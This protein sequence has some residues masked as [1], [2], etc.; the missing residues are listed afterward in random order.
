MTN[1]YTQNDYD[2]TITTM[3]P[4]NGSN[5]VSSIHAM[6]F[7]DSFY[8]FYHAYKYD[9]IYNFHPA[10]N[11]Q[12]MYSR[13]NYDTKRWENISYTLKF[14]T[15]ERSIKSI[16]IDNERIYA[17]VDNGSIYSTTDGNSWYK[18]RANFDAAQTDYEMGI[19]IQPFPKINA[20]HSEKEPDWAKLGDYYYSIDF[21]TVYVPTNTIRLMADMGETNYILSDDDIKLAN[22]YRLQVTSS[23][24]DITSGNNKQTLN[25]LSPIYTTHK[26]MGGS[27]F[28]FSFNGKLMRLVDYANTFQ[29]D[30]YPYKSLKS[31]NDFE[32]WREKALMGGTD[33]YS[34]VACNYNAMF[35]KS[36]YDV[37]NLY[38]T[39]SVNFMSDSSITHYT[40][41]FK[42]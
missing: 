16:R 7:K 13:M 19:Y 35:N 17:E 26:W 25:I 9:K 31:Y 15:N 2:K 38:V 11:G 34:I 20:S 6:S 42:Y 28:L 14:P 8:I 32:V 21:T 41:D 3:F 33:G 18:D 40:L 1:W 36:L 12:Y 10:S 22:I 29:I 4:F 30:S 24:K 37:Y 39:N 23:E 27:S 5:N